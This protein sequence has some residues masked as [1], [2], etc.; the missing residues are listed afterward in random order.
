MTPWCWR[1][2]DCAALD[3]LPQLAA[4]AENSGG[5]EDRQGAGG[6]GDDQHGGKQ[7]LLWTCEY[8][9]NQQR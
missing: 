7:N 4:E 5:A 2:A 8:D 6:S 1:S 3:V 9:S